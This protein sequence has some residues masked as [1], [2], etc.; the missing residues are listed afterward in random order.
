[1]LAVTGHEELQAVTRGRADDL[2]LVTA[3]T[4]VCTMRYAPP[5][6][7]AS[8]PWPATAGRLRTAGRHAGNTAD[9]LRLPR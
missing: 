1:V 3:G 9:A 5:V 8:A 4:D 6:R 7:P 2:A